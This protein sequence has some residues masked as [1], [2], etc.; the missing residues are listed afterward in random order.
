MR[1]CHDWVV[2]LAHIGAFYCAIMNLSYLTIIGGMLR[3]ER[4]ITIATSASGLFMGSDTI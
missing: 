2:P 1:V 4:T 3:L